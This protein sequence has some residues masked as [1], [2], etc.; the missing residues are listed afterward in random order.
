[1]VFMTEGEIFYNPQSA[2]WEKEYHLKIFH[3]IQKKTIKTTIKLEYD[4]VVPGNPV[5]MLPTGDDYIIQFKGGLTNELLDLEEIIREYKK[6]KIQ[7]KEI[8]NVL[9]RF[10]IQISLKDYKRNLNKYIKNDKKKYDQQ[11]SKYEKKSEQINDFFKSY[12]GIDIKGEESKTQLETEIQPETFNKTE[13]ETIQTTKNTQNTHCALY[14]FM[15]VS[16][17]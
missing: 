13:A 16:V 1:M 6:D 7:E 9:S 10:G 11:L 14:V 4:L 15:F 5:R 8:N 2:F 17:Q 12:Y 3:K